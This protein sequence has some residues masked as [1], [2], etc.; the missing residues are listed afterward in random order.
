M[1]KKLKEDF[2]NYIE[3]VDK[4]IRKEVAAPKKEKNIYPLIINE[5]L[6]FQDKVVQV[7][8]HPL[9]ETL[10][11]STIKSFGF[12]RSEQERIAGN[13]L[14]FTS[15]YFGINFDDADYADYAVGWKLS[16]GNFFR[17]SHCYFNKYNNIACDTYKILDDYCRAFERKSFKK[18]HLIPLGH[19]NF[20]VDS[21]NFIDFA[22]RKFTK[23]GFSE[24]LEYDN[25]KTFYSNL[26]V[27]INILSGHW[28]IQAEE[29]FV[30]QN[31]IKDLWI[32]ESDISIPDINIPDI[33]NKPLSAIVLYNWVSQSDRYPVREDAGDELYRRISSGDYDEASYE[34]DDAEVVDQSLNA[35]KNDFVPFNVPFILEINDNLLLPPYHFYVDQQLKDSSIMREL[36]LSDYVRDVLYFNKQGTTDFKEFIKNTSS[37]IENIYSIGKEVDFISRAFHY[38]RKAFFSD[39]LEQLLWHIV[40]LETLFGERKHIGKTIANRVSTILGDSGENREKINKI[41]KVIYDYR[42]NTVHGRKFKKKVSNN[43]L[44]QARHLARKSL[45]WT[46]HFLHYLISGIKSLDDINKRPIREYINSVIDLASDNQLSNGNCLT[47]LPT[48]FPNI[49]NWA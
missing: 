48:G 4:I 44:H 1:N 32:E 9:F 29:E 45:L 7:E 38:L 33:I 14:F 35:L 49:K 39:G 5:S 16:I 34:R 10:I 6:L 3:I 15:R 30:T 21:M 27:D 46:I 19:V 26:A 23:E 22:I 18:I 25:N 40:V 47:N 20:E 37:I 11:K 12:S 8:S 43:H 41:F 42:S 36:S 24:L 28:F 2:V 31:T 13:A 17:R